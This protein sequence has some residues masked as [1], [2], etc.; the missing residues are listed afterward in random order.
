MKKPKTM[1]VTMRFENNWISQLK[2][3]ARKEAYKQNK[4]ISYQNLIKKAVYEK[5]IK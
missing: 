2:Q 4:D 1:P 3:I 5:Y